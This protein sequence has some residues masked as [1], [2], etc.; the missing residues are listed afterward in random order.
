MG[1][2]G[3]GGIGG[4]ERTGGTERNKS[5]CKDYFVLLLSVNDCINCINRCSRLYIVYF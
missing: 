5:Q 2:R 4:T 1:T 3:T